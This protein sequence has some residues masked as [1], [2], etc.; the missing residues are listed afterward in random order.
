[1]KYPAVFLI[2][3]LCIVTVFSGCASM[4]FQDAVQSGNIR[5]VDTLL[6][7]GRIGINDRLGQ[8]RTP[9]FLAAEANQVRMAEFLLGKGADPDI[10]DSSG[11]TALVKA[12][13]LGNHEIVKL[14]LKAGSD[15]SA[16]GAEGMTALMHYAGRSGGMSIIELLIESG[17][18][19]DSMND[20]QFS[21]RALDIALTR[22]NNIPAAYY[23]IEQG[24][25]ITEGALFSALGLERELGLLMLQMIDSVPASALLAVLDDQELF[26]MMIER[27]ADPAEALGTVVR[28]GNV[29]GI[30]MLV[31]AGADIHS[32]DDLLE[33]AANEETARILVTLGVDVQHGLPLHRAVMDEDAGRVSFLVNE[34]GASMGR[35]DQNGRTAL[36]LALF[37]QKFNMMKT[38]LQSEGPHYINHLHD[39]RTVLDLIGTGTEAHVPSG[40]IEEY[41]GVSREE[42]REMLISMGAK[43][44]A[45]L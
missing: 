7:E 39:E 9:L 1:M 10:R 24:A 32:S 13:Q 3:L 37:H 40:W 29:K 15:P 26:N 44:S 19:P 30:Q 42:I 45:Q 16:R 35:L 38:L 23:L 21:R 5:E 22:R 31:E 25:T 2:S 11:D 18:D 28:S 41:K 12:A 36:H 20:R 34:A 27:G 4:Q 33:R 8:G 17:A 14:L 43:S 6:E